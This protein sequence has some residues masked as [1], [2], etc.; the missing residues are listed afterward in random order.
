ML[1][2]YIIA[3]CNG[4]GKTTAATTL[5]PTL[6]DN[7]EFVNADEIAH[8]ISP[9]NPEAVAIEAGRRMLNRIDELIRQRKSFTI[10]TT[11]ATRSY[12]RLFERAHS[13]GYQ[14]K[15]LYFWLTSPGLAIER[16]AAR[17]RDGGHNIPTDVIKRRY[18]KGLQNL[19][20]LFIPISDEWYIYNNSNSSRSMIAYG[21]RGERP[22][23]KDIITLKQMMV[24]A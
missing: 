14:I 11:L 3:G 16:V 10:E 18:A 2:L 21:S 13:E 19:F 6:F 5:L 12:V 20:N 24:Y 9:S 7:T 17:V 4:A 22:N 1:T 15:L 23:I 8:A